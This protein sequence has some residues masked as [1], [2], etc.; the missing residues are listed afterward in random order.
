MGVVENFIDIRKDLFPF[1]FSIT[2]WY[3]LLAV[4]FMFNISKILFLVQWQKILDLHKDTTTR[5]QQT[6]VGLQKDTKNATQAVCCPTLKVH[7][8]DNF[9]GSD[10]EI[11]TFSQLVMHKC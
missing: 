1:L 8:H 2:T 10:F 4:Q 7:N 9:L 5:K 11:C 6:K 3:K